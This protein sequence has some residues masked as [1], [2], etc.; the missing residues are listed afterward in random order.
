MSLWLQIMREYIERKL[1]N[2]RQRDSMLGL[3]VE[4][5][6]HFMRYYLSSGRH[7]IEPKNEWAFTFGDEQKLTDVPATASL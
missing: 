1:P 6:P 2:Q 3:L 7:T 4:E 5:G